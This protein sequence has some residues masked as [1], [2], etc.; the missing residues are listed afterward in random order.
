MQERDFREAI[1]TFLLTGYRFHKDIIT[2]ILQQLKKLHAAIGQ[3][4]TYRFYACSLLIVYDGD[5]ENDISLTGSDLLPGGECGSA[6]EGMRTANGTF[7]AKALGHNG[8]VLGDSHAD[9]DSPTLTPCNPEGDAA[10]VADVR[11]DDASGH[12]NLSTCVAET[13]LCEPDAA[14]ERNASSASSKDFRSAADGSMSEGLTTT[15]TTTTKHRI[16]VRMVDFA[17]STFKGFGSD[18]VVHEG[19]DRGC[20]LGLETLIKI[21]SEMKLSAI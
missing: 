11:H 19:V 15:T 12:V 4:P 3:L 16:D 20:L 17:H 7:E 14:G 6:G 18:V 9:G 21:V 1:E 8:E 13:R 10:S 2:V 5:F